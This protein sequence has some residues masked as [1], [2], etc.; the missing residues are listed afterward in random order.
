MTR[1]R[2]SNRYLRN[3]I[4]ENYKD[5]NLKNYISRNIR[6]FRNIK[7]FYKEFNNRYYIRYYYFHR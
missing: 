3:K 2:D 7:K 1:T 6:I 5:R 4:K